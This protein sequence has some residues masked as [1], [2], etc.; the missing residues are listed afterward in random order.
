MRLKTVLFALAVVTLTAVTEGHPSRRHNKLTWWQNFLCSNW[1]NWPWIQNG[2]TPE[3]TERISQMRTLVGSCRA[4]VGTCPVRSCST[5]TKHFNFCPDDGYVCPETETRT[6]DCGFF[7]E[8]TYEY[9]KQCGCCKDNGVI[10][11]GIVKDADTNEPLSKIIVYFNGR[12]VVYTGED[13]QFKSTIKSSVRSIVV[14]TKDRSRN[15]MAA[16]KIVDIPEG[17]RGPVE[18]ELLAI[19][20]SKPVEINSTVDTV[21]SLSNDPLDPNAGNTVIEIQ[22]NSFTDRRGRP[23]NG[24]VNARV[25]FIDTV[26]SPDAVAPGRFQTLDGDTIEPLITDGV[27]S[28]NFESTGGKFIKLSAPVKFTGREGMKVWELN[29][30]TGLWEPARIVQGRRKRQVTL[31]DIINIESDRWYNIDKIPGAP[32]CYFKGRIFNETSGDEIMSSATTSFRPEI[33]AYTSIGQ[34]LRLYSGFTSE[35]STTCYEVRC[36]VVNNPNNSLAG[37]INMSATEVISFGGINLPSKIYLT[38]REFVNYDAVI[39]PRLS[40]VQYEIAPNDVDV[41]VNF[42]SN[43]AGPFYRNRNACESSSVTQPALHFLKPE[44]PNYEHAPDVDEIC[45]ARI[46]FKEEGYF[47]NYASNL[48][49]LPNVTGISVWEQNGTKSY[50]IDDAQMEFSTDGN[51]TFIFICLKYR[52]SQENESTTVYLDIDIPT[53]NVTYNRTYPNGSVVSFTYPRQEFG[54]YGD[55][56]EGSE[57]SKQAGGDNVTTIEGS[58]IAPEDVAS[59]P[60]FYDSETNDCTQESDHETFAYVFYCYSK[61]RGQVS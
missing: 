60:D 32:R 1:Y 5:K 22:A 44:P 10:V 29:T 58:F 14:T 19:Q 56:A 27:A 52:C 9:V 54:C 18:V 25:T 24:K 31:D 50:F 41:F 48:T 33:T 39:K 13:G 49:N 2:I 59:G 51:E 15:Y 8:R 36:P 20:K 43:T 42:V 45:T 23:Y 12:F 16:V 3:P 57:F 46:A 34:R 61:Q 30:R 37:F 55:I 17:F 40:A 28:F 11:T 47:F 21:L 26:G 6:A 53:V 7:G 35:P 38:P 4:D